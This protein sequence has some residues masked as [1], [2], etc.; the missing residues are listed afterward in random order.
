MLVPFLRVRFTYVRKCIRRRGG[1]FCDF[2]DE[3]LAR[4]HIFFQRFAIPYKVSYEDHNRRSERF[5]VE[6]PHAP[7][8]ATRST[9]LN[10]LRRNSR[11]TTIRVNDFSEFRLG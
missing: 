10:R 8:E 5:K 2:L 7:D 6:I 3:R 9:G 11:V 4:R 1:Y